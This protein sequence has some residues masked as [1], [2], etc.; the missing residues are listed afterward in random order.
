MWC[1]T[2]L[3]GTERGVL[4]VNRLAFFMIGGVFWNGAE[5]CA[6]KNVSYPFRAV[7]C[8]NGAVLCANRVVFCANGVDAVFER[9]ARLCILTSCGNLSIFIWWAR[10]IPNNF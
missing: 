2:V 3:C 10:Q 9:G 1:T 4:C 5:V 7:L 6:S 8:A